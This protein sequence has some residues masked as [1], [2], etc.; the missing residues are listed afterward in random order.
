[1]NILTCAHVRPRFHR[2]KRQ[3][4]KKKINITKRK[5]RKNWKKEGG[6]TRRD[7]WSSRILIRLARIYRVACGLAFVVPNCG[8]VNFLGEICSIFFSALVVLYLTHFLFL[9]YKIKFYRQIALLHENT[10]N[11]NY[12]CKILKIATRSFPRIIIK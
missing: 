10:A 4:K 6:S 12:A 3:A 1:M 8:Y 5:N 11:D 9:T 7:A 2:A